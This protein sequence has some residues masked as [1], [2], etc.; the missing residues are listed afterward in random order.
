LAIGDSA[1][2]MSPIGGV[3]INLAVQD[4]VAAANILAA[5]LARGE[6]VGGLL[7]KVQERRM[8]PTRV[9][10]RVQKFIQDRIIW[11]VLS[12]GDQPVRPPIIARL[13]DRFAPLR[14]IPG[15]LMGVG[16]RRERVRS[17]AAPIRP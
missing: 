6:D 16:I 9:I 1:H 14:S 13:F 8:L 4:A 12:N 5:P 3:G 2:A 11:P 7:S 10:Q 15:R 17:P